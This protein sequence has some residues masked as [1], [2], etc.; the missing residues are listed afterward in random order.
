MLP[1]HSFYPGG[2]TTLLAVFNVAGRP[3]EQQTI[4]AEANGQRVTITGNLPAGAQVSAEPV[5]PETAVVLAGDHVSDPSAIVTALDITLL[6][7]GVKYQPSAY[8]ESVT[9]SITGINAAVEE[10][11]SLCVL[12]VPQ[13]ADPAVEVVQIDTA[14]KNTVAFTADEFS[15]YIVTINTNYTLTFAS[16]EYTLQNEAGTALTDEDPATPE[17]EITTLNKFFKF[18]VVPTAGYTVTDVSVAMATGASAAANLF[19]PVNGMYTVSN[20]TAASGSQIV[21]IQT[22][23]SFTITYDANDGGGTSPVEKA[24]F[25]GQSATLAFPADIGFTPPANQYFASWNTALD[26]TGT[27]YAAGASVPISDALTLYAQWTGTAAPFTAKLYDNANLATSAYTELT[28]GGAV[29]NGWDYNYPSRYLIIDANLT[30]KNGGTI[31]ITL[32]TGMALYDNNY[33]KMSGHPNMAN[34]PVFTIYDEDA[35]TNGYQQGTGAYSNPRTGTLTYTFSAAATTETLT[36]PVT[37]DQTIWDRSTGLANLSGSKPALTVTMTP[38]TGTVITKTLSKVLSS[39]GTGPFI[40]PDYWPDNVPIGDERSSMSYT[41]VRNADT[42]WRTLMMEYILPHKT[43]NGETIYA[44]Y[45]GESQTGDTALNSYALVLTTAGFTVDASDPTKLIYTW[46]DHKQSNFIYLSPVL[47]FPADKFGD[48]EQLSFTVTL[49]GETYSGAVITDT[50]NCKTTAVARK[51]DIV[52]NTAPRSICQTGSPAQVS[53]I[54]GNMSLKNVGLSN[55]GRLQVT[56]TFDSGNSAGS[57]QHNIDVSAFSLPQTNLAS[58]NQATFNATCTMVNAGNSSSFTHTMT[59]LSKDSDYRYPQYGCLLLASD[60]VAAY[61]AEN[62][63]SATGDWYFKTVTYEIPMIPLG[64][65]LY[66]PTAQSAITR[67]PVWWISRGLPPGQAR[68]LTSK[69]A[70]MLP[71]P[72]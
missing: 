10:D 23:Q 59:G 53:G 30:G 38:S 70:R 31:S 43:V 56:Y 61:N 46:T 8:G 57:S 2:E 34:E 17:I 1:A 42:Y 44:E 4:Y 62:A 9:V 35:G 26:G 67:L 58:L 15:V 65:T 7:D 32:P 22:A 50:E 41:S 37:F 27:A 66:Y 16:G 20:V 68:T 6:V 28:E 19:G 49:T 39:A 55:S 40:Y 14:T 12:H 3:M 33:T 45:V 71:Q 64:T 63:D 13:G 11:Q 21:T 72:P 36:I 18:K 29:G 51:S 69:A 24:V 48:G 54:L 5:S 25:F 47:R 60:V 52:I